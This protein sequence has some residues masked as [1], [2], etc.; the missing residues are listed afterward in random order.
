MRLH[1]ALVDYIPRIQARQCDCRN[2]IYDSGVLF[3]LYCALTSRPL[4]CEF[5]TAGIPE[6][7]DDCI[8]AIIREL[9]PPRRQLTPQH[10]YSYQ[11]VSLV[12]PFPLPAPT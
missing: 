12:S 1:T 9:P 6:E 7:Y 8:E 3:A 5:I 11:V 2:T 4:E 10:K